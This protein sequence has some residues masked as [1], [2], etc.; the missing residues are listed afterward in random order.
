MSEVG[1]SRKGLKLETT[2]EI[3]KVS[4]SGGFGD[5]ADGGDGVEG[6]AGAT[7]VAGAAGEG[8]RVDV[9]LPEADTGT[10]AGRVV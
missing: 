5:G 7:G 4:P 8:S 9:R 1:V 6:V 3:L 2:L 10:E